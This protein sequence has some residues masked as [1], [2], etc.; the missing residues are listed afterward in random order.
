MVAKEEIGGLV[1]FQMIGRSLHHEGARM[2]KGEH[3]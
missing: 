1:L 2:T 3:D